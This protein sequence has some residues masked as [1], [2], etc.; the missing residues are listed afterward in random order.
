MMIKKQLSLP[1]PFPPKPK[2]LP[3]PPQQQ[4]NNTM[5]NKQEDIPPLSHPHPHPQF[6]ALNSLML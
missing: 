1:K 3:L 2:P 6:V 5:I 4:H